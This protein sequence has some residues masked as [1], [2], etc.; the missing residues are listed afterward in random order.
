M[1]SYS[2]R[3]HIGYPNWIVRPATAAAKQTQ[4]LSNANALIVD[5]FSRSVGRRPTSISVDTLMS[6][7]YVLTTVESLMYAHIMAVA[8]SCLSW[9]C[10]F[11][12]VK[13]WHAWL[14]FAIWNAD[15]N[16]KCSSLMFDRKCSADILSSVDNYA[17]L[18]LDVV[19]CYLRLQSISS[20]PDA[21][22]CMLSADNVFVYSLLFSRHRRTSCF[23]CSYCVE[24]LYVSRRLMVKQQQVVD[25]LFDDEQFGKLSLNFF[26]SNKL[27]SMI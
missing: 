8:W 16:C 26:A 20:L 23:H 7:S 3:V 10:D 11:Q 9:W 5:C 14:K 13:L 15:W 25:R 6:L 1:T 4:D 12:L 17:L 18:C 22:V 21:G 24:T 2:A 19:W 27:L